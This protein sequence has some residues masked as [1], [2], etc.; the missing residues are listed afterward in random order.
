MTS[1]NTT[2]KEDGMAPEPCASEACAEA[3]ALSKCVCRCGGW[4]HASK[5]Q[6][7]LFT[8]VLLTDASGHDE[9]PRRSR[10]P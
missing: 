2:T 1:N 10:G 4:G 9:G 7:P 5:S 8:R 3:D 6:Q